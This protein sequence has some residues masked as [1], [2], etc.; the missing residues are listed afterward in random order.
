M[1]S[2]SLLL[3]VLILKFSDNKGYL[4]T[5]PS[6]S[7]KFDIFVLLNL[8]ALKKST[9]GEFPGDCLGDLSGDILPEIRLTLKAK[10]FYLRVY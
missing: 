9:E 6:S 10:S 5:N 1:L 3:N 8:F 4:I 2:R 7:N